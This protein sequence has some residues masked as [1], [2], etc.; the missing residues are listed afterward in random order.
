M[1]PPGTVVTH[2]VL[3]QDLSAT[4][5]DIAGVAIPHT[6]TTKSLLPFIYRRRNLEQAPQYV[7]NSFSPSRKWRL[8]VTD[9]RV[10]DADIP[11][12]H[13]FLYTDSNASQ[14]SPIH[15]F[16]SISNV[17][18]TGQSGAWIGCRVTWQGSNS[19]QGRISWLNVRTNEEVSAAGVVKL[20]KE[21]LHKLES[22]CR[23]A[24][25]LPPW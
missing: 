17:T 7:V 10:D 1:F 9:I 12:L 23:N 3:M 2:P 15:K 13:S 20:P 16:A 14:I 6:M 5:L 8:A 18:E 24:C 4:F 21:L 19:N 11:F 25:K 22:K